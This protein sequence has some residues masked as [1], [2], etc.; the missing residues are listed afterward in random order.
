VTLYR[1]ESDSERAKVLSDSADNSH[2]YFSHDYF[3]HD[4]VL[5][6]HIF[7]DE[8]PPNDVSHDA[9]DDVSDDA[10]SEALVSALA[11]PFPD[12]PNNH[13][14]SV[15][16]VTEVLDDPK[17]V[18]LVQSGTK[19]KYD[20]LVL[21]SRPINQGFALYR[22]GSSARARPFAL[23]VLSQH[24]KNYPRDATA[25]SAIAVAHD[26]DLQLIERTVG[27]SRIFMPKLN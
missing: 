10:L 21:V 23:L 4:D 24:Q 12:D 19:Q 2:D 7:Y 17:V 6:N 20:T 22:G 11:T 14:G 25:D 13:R 1:L 18:C 27:P 16:Q 5:N 26:N 3:S 9:R 8:V 15:M